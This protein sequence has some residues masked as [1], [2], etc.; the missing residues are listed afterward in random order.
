M[1]RIFYYHCNYEHSIS[2]RQLKMPIDVQI[3]IRIE[4]HMLKIIFL[5]TIYKLYCSDTLY[6]PI[7]IMN[8]GIQKHVHDST[9]FIFSV[10][11]IK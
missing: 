8:S 4:F 6:M 10:K 5:H 7:M 9:F 2:K 1:I 11:E 3:S